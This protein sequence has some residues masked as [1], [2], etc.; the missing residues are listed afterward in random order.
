MVLKMEILIRLIYRINKIV[1]KKKIYLMI[2]QKNIN[3]KN[4]LLGVGANMKNLKMK[5]IIF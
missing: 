3:K 5:L 1:I 4:M 2:F